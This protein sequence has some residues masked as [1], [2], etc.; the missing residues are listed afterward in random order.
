MKNLNPRDNISIVQLIALISGTLTTVGFLDTRGIAKDI[1]IDVWIP[2][3]IVFLLSP[4]FVFT[5][6]K[7]AEKYPEESIITYLP[8]I[9]GKFL[10]SALGFFLSLYYF[11][12]SAIAFRL[13]LEITKIYLLPNT[14]LEFIVLVQTI[15]LFYAVWFGVNGIGRLAELIVPISTFLFVT[16]LITTFFQADY[17]NIL[18][19]AEKGILPIIKKMSFAF[20]NY[21]GLG[22]ILFLYPFLN[23]KKKVIKPVL[24][25]VLG[26]GLIIFLLNITV[27]AIFR[28]EIT[29]L[30]FPSIALFERINIQVMF[31]E[32]LV[33]FLLLVI[34]PVFFIF[35]TIIFYLSVLGF[36]DLFRL[37]EHTVFTILLMP[38]YFLMSNLPLSIADIFITRE[39][40][41]WVSIFVLFLPLLL[42]IMTKLKRK[43]YS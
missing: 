16:L 5:N 37:R 9:L 1:S 19:I 8:D 30:Y 31:L 23:R 2:I 40:T 3:L 17:S 35:N 41:H 27:V 29:D 33:F 32:R 6:I 7:L 42:L 11:V 20:P 25:A 4:L 43:V 14:P 36:S 28:Y 13:F 24:F 21:L 22:M 15:V 38:V 12:V 10:G 26:T 34:F 39:A 18:P